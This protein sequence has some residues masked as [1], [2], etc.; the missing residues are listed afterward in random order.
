MVNIVTLECDGEELDGM[1][2]G[3]GGRETV[4]ISSQL[5]LELTVYTSD[6]AS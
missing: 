6:K 1:L 2:G 3:G 5:L 4:N